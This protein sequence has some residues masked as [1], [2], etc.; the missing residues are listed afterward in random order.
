MNRP[1]NQAMFTPTAL[2]AVA[3][4]AVACASQA[5][6]AATPMLKYDSGAQNAAAKAQFGASTQVN[7]SSSFN[8]MDTANGNS[9]FSV[10]C[11]DPLN[12][13]G[14]TAKSYFAPVT[15]SDFSGFTASSYKALYNTANYTT[16]AG[17]TPTYGLKN[18]TDTSALSGNVLASVNTNL[19]NLFKYA[20]ADSLNNG[21]FTVGATTYNITAAQKS[22]AL[23]YAIWEIEGDKAGQ[24]SRS[25]GGLKYLGGATDV[26]G[27]QI[28]RLLGALN[29]TSAWTSLGLGASTNYNFTFYTSNAIG[30]SQSLV[31]VSKVPEPGSLALAG[32][33]IA[34]VVV[35]RRKGRKA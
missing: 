26:V 30:T 10:Y 12:S 29:G 20:Y 24:Y 9:V 23:Q 13:I 3:V 18:T 34:G 28:D 4:L 19:T 2:K 31:R 35:T 17:N 15:T 1:Q 6:L 21:S 14:T 25:V 16:V 7:L 33:A 32:L 27:L 8:V 22:E 11:L 5:V